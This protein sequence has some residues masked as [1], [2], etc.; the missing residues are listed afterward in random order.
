[1]FLIDRI[2]DENIVPYPGEPQAILKMFQEQGSR[3]GRWQRV[4]PAENYRKY[5]TFAEM[6]TKLNT[7][8]SRGL[9]GDL[10]GEESK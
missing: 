7:F 4:Y 1:M 6:N 9:N 10:D 8:V 3:A 5:E 2:G